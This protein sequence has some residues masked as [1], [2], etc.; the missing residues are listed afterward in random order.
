MSELFEKL[1]FDP[2]AFL[3]SPLSWILMLLFGLNLY[4][5]QFWQ[6]YYEEGI[7]QQVQVDT[8]VCEIGT[9]S[10]KAENKFLRAENAEN[11]KILRKQNEMLLRLTLNKPTH[12]Q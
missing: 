2:K 1:G 5:V 6:N 3:K 8:L 4:Q 10:L 9:N 12:P 7:K 11:L